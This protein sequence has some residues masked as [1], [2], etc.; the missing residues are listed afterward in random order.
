MGMRYN[1]QVINSELLLYLDAKNPKSYSGT[2]TT[3]YDISGN[4]RNGSLINS[5]SYVAGA[6]PYFNFGG[7]NEQIRVGAVTSNYSTNLTYSIWYYGT[8][9]AGTLFWDDDSQGGGDAWVI[10]NS[11]GKFVS[12]RDGDGFGVLTSVGGATAGVWCNFTLVCSS[13]SPNKIFYI[14]G[15]FDTSNN[16]AIATRSNRSYVTLGYSFDGANAIGGGAPLTGRIGM[17][18]I[19]GKAL[20]ADEVLQNYNATKSRFGL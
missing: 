7:T 18:S 10:I 2:G 5:P 12:N 17:F 14:N 3:W 19:Y 16:V 11:S 20:N 1:S 15:Q 9:F 13:T 6:I 8:S 4:R